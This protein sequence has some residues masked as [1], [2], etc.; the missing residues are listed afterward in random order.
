LTSTDPDTG[1]TFTYSLVTGTGSTDNT[2]FAIVG[3]QLNINASPNFE[4]KSSYAIR[5]RTTDQGGLTYETPLTV[6]VNN[7]NE[8]PTALVLSSTSINE[9]VAANSAVGTFTSTDPDTG[10][11]FTYSLVTGTGSTD[12]TAFAIVGNQLNIVASPNFEAK[13]SYAIRVRTTDQ[14]GLTYETPL[15]VTVNNLNETPTALALSNS[16]INENVA[17]NST[18]GTFTSTDPDTGNTFTYSLVTGTGSTDNTA[19]AIVGNQL[20]INASPNFEAKSSYAIRVRT[21]DQGGLTYETPLTVTV[22]NL[23]ETPTAL[24]LSN[25]TINEN[26]AANSTVGTFTS[27][28]P[29][30]GNTF[31]YSLVTGTGSTDNTAF[32]IV[33]NQLNINASPNFEAKSSY[34]IRVRTTDQ[35][36]LTY[37]T[38]LT[39][40]VNNLNETPTALALSN[41]TINENVAANSTVGT[42]TSTDPDTGNTFTYSLVTGTGS[43]DNTAFAIVGNQLNINASPNFEAKSSYAIRVR[44]TDQGGLTYETPLTVTVNNLN[45]TPTALALSNSTINE[46]VAANS[47]VGTFTSTDPDTGNTFTY[48]LVTGTG[49]TDNTAFAIVGNQ[50]NINASPNFEAK[51]SYAI[52]V[53]TTDQGGLTYETPLTVTVNNLNETPTALALSNS[54]INE[55]VAANSTVGTFTSTDPDT[56]NT[57][58]YSLVTGTG[59]TDNT[60]FAI[61]GNQLNINASPNFE[62]KSSY[63]IRVRTTDQGGLTYETPLTVTVN[64][65][66]ET[67]TALA[68][69][70]STINENVAANSTVGTFTS[71]DPDTGNTFTYSLVTGTGSTDN[72]AFAIVGNQLN[73]NASPNFEAKSSYA[74]RVRT[75]DQGGLTYEAP[76]TVTVANVNET[77]TALALSS[78][79]INEN[80]AANSAVGTLTSTDLDV[81]DTFTYSLVTG[82]GDTDNTAFTLVGD[83]LKINAS[84]DFETKS[85][86]SIRLKTTDAAGLTFE[87]ALTVNINNLADQTPTN[88]TLSSNNIDENVAANSIVGTLTSTDLDVGDTFTYSLVTGTGD[89]DNTAFT[90][91]GDQLKINASPDFETKSSY[92]IRLKT[93]DA[94]G[95]T[96]EKA[97]TV[98]INNL[99]EKLVS[100]TPNNDIFNGTASADQIDALAG[101]DRIYGEG[102]NDTIDGGEGNDILY[103]GDDDDLLHGGNGSDRLYGDAGNDQLYG[104]AGNDIL[105]GGDGDNLLDGGAGSDQIYGNTGIDTF[106]LAAG[107]GQDLINGF[108]DGKDK[109]RLDGG[110]TFA[111]LNITTSGTSTLIKVLASGVTLASLINVNSTLIGSADFI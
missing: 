50:L 99:N 81:G 29:D 77:P 6:T 28:D 47:T 64:N 35:G 23:N 69:S 4:A 63:A 36:G 25:S 102:G 78:T 106:V 27:T 104:D 70:N 76:L 45:E 18:V 34:A 53:R 88:L 2:A 72:T 84:P 105:Y 67:P 32:A 57:F 73:I 92:S 58:T 110:L 75:T 22:N 26:V 62:A 30:T 12:N 94:A 96:F 89:T 19:F 103:G 90:L 100:L 8:T 107:M 91:V 38:P 68:L 15:T 71:T 46:N 101:S 16:T 52:R 39:V 83:Q 41:S 33:G 55:N 42:F 11:T 108:E 79:S 74:I 111:D 9:N 1:D 3:N 87:K 43:T 24:A 82:T 80:V 86:Y 44:T 97:L 49:S 93:T 65:L 98:N 48:S 56:G 51:S 61:V 10:N 54:T 17:A 85:S 37:E 95:L 60:A 7:L 31:T 14:G 5:V 21:T 20:N 59:S 109:I 13:S 40:T 66:N